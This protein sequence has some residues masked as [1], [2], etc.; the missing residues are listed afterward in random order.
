M[1]M[2]RGTGDRVERLGFVF[3]SRAVESAPLSLSNSVLLGLTQPLGPRFFQLKNNN[4]T[5]L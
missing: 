5:C 3:F 1:A 2:A 4:R